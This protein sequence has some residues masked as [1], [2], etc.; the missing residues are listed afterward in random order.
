M[1]FDEYQFL[2]Y[3]IPGS[4]AV[5][6]I[7]FFLAPFIGDGVINNFKASPEG[8][9]GIVG[10]AFGA[11]LAIGYVIYTFY[12]TCSYNK[13]A[14]DSTK[15]RILHYLEKQKPDC[16]K[17]SEFE[18][19]ATLDM[20]YDAFDDSSVSNRVASKARGMWSH[21]NARKVCAIYVPSFSIV[22]SVIIILFAHLIKP[23][24]FDFSNLYRFLLLIPIC[25]IVGAVSIC[26]VLW[27]ESSL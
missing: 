18:K 5:I 25:L 4:L 20:L 12:D 24:I 14:M 19:K 7:A 26:F 1:G 27:C 23:N 16:K 13:A 3:F 8:L 9:L 15:R 22:F 10:A 2:R 21:F 11:S 6:Y 17:L